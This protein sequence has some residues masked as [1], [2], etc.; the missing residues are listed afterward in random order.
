MG[1]MGMKTRQTGRRV[2]TLAAAIIGIGI[3]PLSGSAQ[4]SPE[5]VVRSRNEAVKSALDA[6]GDSISDEVRDEL[7]DVINGLIDFHELAKRALRREWDIRTPEEQQQFVDIFRTLVRNSSVRKLEVYDTDSISYRPA[8][9]DGDQSRVLTV[10][11]EDGKQVEIVYLMHRV[12]GEWL[13]WDVIIDGSS[14]LRTYQDS[15]QREI[16]ATSYQAMYS[17]LV[18][19]LARDGG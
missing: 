16:K 8:E 18:D 6:A 9:T 13:A 12:E 4:Q 15:F 1:G 3:L 11:H 7:K 17:R 19:R 10:A 2:T 14:T 5:E